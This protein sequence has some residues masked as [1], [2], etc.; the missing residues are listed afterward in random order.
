MSNNKGDLN[1][2]AQGIIKET[3]ETEIGEMEIEMEE[4]EIIQMEIR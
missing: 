1:T 4:T 2:M 3:K